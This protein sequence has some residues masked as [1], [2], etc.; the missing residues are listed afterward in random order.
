MLI[1][2]FFKLAGY[3]ARYLTDNQPL[4]SILPFTRHLYRTEEEVSLGCTDTHHI[5]RKSLVLG[6]LDH[7]GSVR[8][9]LHG[10]VVLESLQ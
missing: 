4:V 6:M 8:S 2:K 5:S 10:G 9:A 3:R 1:Y 7:L